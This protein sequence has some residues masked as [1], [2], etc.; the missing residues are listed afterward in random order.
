MEK[1]IPIEGSPN[2]KRD[3]QSHGVVN[4]DTNGLKAAKERKKKA[5]EMQQEIADLRKQVERL[6]KFVEESFGS[7]I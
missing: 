1:F 3:V 4:C 2:L 7:K 6:T 5:L